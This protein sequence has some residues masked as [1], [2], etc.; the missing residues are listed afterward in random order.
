MVLN[1]NRHV[2]QLTKIDSPEVNVCDFGQLIYKKGGKNTQW[3]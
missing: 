1:K 3:R 2:V